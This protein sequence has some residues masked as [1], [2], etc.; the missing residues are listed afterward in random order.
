MTTGLTVGCSAAPDPIR[1]RRELTGYLVGAGS[2]RIQ[3]VPK[4]PP[5]DDKDQS[6][7]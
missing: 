1:T 6:V 4:I 5:N 3:A 7:T 2:P